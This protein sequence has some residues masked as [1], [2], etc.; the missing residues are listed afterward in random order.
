MSF[1]QTH[2][3]PVLKMK[4]G[5]K[6]AL[7]RLSPTVRVRITPVF[8][9]VARDTNKK[10]TSADHIETSFKKFKPAVEE[11]KRYFLDCREI[12]PD[13]PEAVE[14]VFRR[15][16]E[17]GPVFV[18]VTGITRSVDVQAALANRASGLAL[19]LTREEFESGVVQTELL[20]F[21][22]SNGVP[23]E[24]IDLIVDL[25]AVDDMVLPGVQALAAAFLTDIPDP[26][27]WRTLT[28]SASAFPTGMGGLERRSHDLIDRLDWSAWR[29]GVRD[30]GALPR[31]PTFSDGV[32]QHPSGVENID[33]RTMTPSASVR[34][35]TGD[36]WLR[37]KGVSIKTELP[38][39]QFQDLATTLVYGHLST[40]FA[41]ASHCDG[42]H[43]MTCA[44]QG[45]DN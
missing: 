33:W 23:R 41:G 1:D 17:L 39:Q 15:A 2:Y 10:P 16:T 37:I 14:D 9:V 34:Y 28:L 32:I 21:V 22:K 43:G 8:E 3:V 36:Q 5:E 19:R 12:A 26:G 11:L 13:G 40:H 42:C 29:D 7:A 6:E 30:G 27:S 20:S 25:G 35:T 24:V 44:A 18:P 4:G 38:S 45:A 31:V